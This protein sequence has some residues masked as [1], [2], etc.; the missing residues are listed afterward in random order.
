MRIMVVDDSRAMRM[1]VLRTLKQAGFRDHTFVEAADGVEALAA[2]KAD[3]PDL[4]LSDWNMPN[5]S[6]IDLLRNLKT[7][8][9]D[10]KFGFVTSESTPEMRTLSSEAGALFMI[11]KP[12]DEDTFRDALEDFI[13]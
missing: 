6:G 7:E 2:I 5:M 10:L 4:V 3:P 9:C 1:I 13:N 11:A 12:F 8:G